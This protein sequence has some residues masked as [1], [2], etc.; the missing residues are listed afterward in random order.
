MVAI[1]SRRYGYFAFVIFKVMSASHERFPSLEPLLLIFDIFTET[2]SVLKSFV[3]VFLTFSTNAFL[4]PESSH[5]GVP[6][7]HAETS[8]IA[9]IE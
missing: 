5:F 1:T 3:I 2:S 9:Q 6:E 8:A 7:E 4:I